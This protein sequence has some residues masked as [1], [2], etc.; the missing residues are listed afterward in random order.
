[1]KKEDLLRIGVISN[2]HGIHG[3]V[4]VFP[5]TDYPE[6]FEELE[7]IFLDNNTTLLSMKIEKVRYFKNMIILKFKGYDNINE[8]ECYKGKDLFITREQAVPLEDGEYFISDLIGSQVITDDGRELG[9]L[10]DVLETGANNVFL[11]KKR[12]GGELLLPYIP[13]CVLS[14]DIEEKLVTVHMMKGLE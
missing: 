10:F 12:D 6:Q 8:I 5:T 3:E 7:D 14:I 11:V 1:M 13:D 2:T 4:K 9:E